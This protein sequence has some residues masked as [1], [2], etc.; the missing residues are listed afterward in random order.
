MM[1]TL[2]RH[3]SPHASPPDRTLEVTKSGN[4]SMEGKDDLI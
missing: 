4:E 2:N 3:P 1:M